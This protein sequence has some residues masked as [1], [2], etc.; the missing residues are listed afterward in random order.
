M[1]VNQLYYDF[2]REV[3]KLRNNMSMTNSNFSHE[4]QMLTRQVMQLKESMEYRNREME[5]KINDLRK[6]V[7]TL[8]TIHSINN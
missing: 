2:T 5:R 3:E 7:Q 1:I 6:M 4:S 8:S